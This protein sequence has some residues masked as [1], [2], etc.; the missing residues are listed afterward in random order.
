MRPEETVVRSV[1]VEVGVGVPVVRAVTAGPPFDRALDGTGTCGSEEVLERRGRVVSAVSPQTMISSS[2]TQSIVAKES[3]CVR[4]GGSRVLR[5]KFE[6]SPSNE[7]PEDSERGSLPLEVHSKGTIEG[8]RGRNSQGKDTNPLNLVEEVLELDWRQLGDSGQ[9]V[10]DII[11]GNM[12]VRGLKGPLSGRGRLGRGEGH[13]VQRRGARL[14]RG[15]LGNV[16]DIV[17]ESTAGHGGTVNPERRRLVGG[18]EVKVARKC[19][20]PFYAG[21]LGVGESHIA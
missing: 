20:V 9:G 8:K 7:V 5:P 14:A 1:G 15:G 18:G 16:R 12:E 17:L 6:Y 21:P 13:V 2:N 19:G 11:I 10:L 3:A 4:F